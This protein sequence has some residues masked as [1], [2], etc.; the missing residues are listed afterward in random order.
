MTVNRVQSCG[1]STRFGKGVVPCRGQ[2]L[3]TTARLAPKGGTGWDE[4]EQTIDIFQY[5]AA[6]EGNDAF[7]LNF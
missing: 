1:I 6:I 7:R 4:A 2:I 5:Y 3:L